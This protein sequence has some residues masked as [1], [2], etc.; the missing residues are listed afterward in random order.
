[1]NLKKL[2]VP[3]L[4]LVFVVVLGVWWFRPG[5]AR[6]EQAVQ[7]PE[8][9]VFQA[10][11]AS[12]VSPATPETPL[13]DEAAPA[14]APQT[15][16]TTVPRRR[17]TPREAL[18]AGSATV[19]ESP[20][21]PAG[22]NLVRRH[23]VVR[24]AEGVFKHPYV[25]VTETYRLTPDEWARDPELRW[26]GDDRLVDAL[27]E[28][29]DHVV[30]RVREGMNAELLR[31]ALE[32]TGLE[33]YQELRTPGTFILRV[34]FH[35]VQAIGHGL[36]VA[37]GLPD[38]IASAQPNTIFHAAFTTPDDLAENLWGLWN[39]SN[40][41]HISAPYAWDLTTG[42]R[43]II[44]A[45]IDTGVDYRH[46]DL[47]ANMW[48]NPDPNAQDVH[49]YDFYNRN[50]DPLDD[51]GHGTHCAGTIGAVG[52]NNLGI[53]GVNWEVSIMGIKF[54]S[55]TG[56]G[57]LADAVDAVNYA[58]EKGAH[59]TNNSWGAATDPNREGDLLREAFANQL[60]AGIGVIAAAGNSFSDN[61]IRPQVPAAYPL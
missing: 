49:G 48:T 43:D 18:L 31:D 47:A 35:S 45:V 54:L 22:E 52:N 53:V 30:V 59:L 23:R 46:P 57:S 6:V 17:V 8:T 14:Q 58:T 36:R 7:S 56:S 13:S 39:N 20:P 9:P 27:E 29:A 3:A 40:D 32:G 2:F 10:P 44:V 5:A 60:A 33:V 16:Q 21:V 28:V 15:P 1:M 55:R 50:P 25:R 12:Q 26:V 37:E 11:A 41:H 38:V 34:P 42:S 24:V 51:H 61:A 19:S 4:S